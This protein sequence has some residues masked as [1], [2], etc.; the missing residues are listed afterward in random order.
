MKKILVIGAGIVGLSIAYYLNKH[1][2]EIKILDKNKAAQEASFAAAGMLAAQSEFEL[3]DDFMDQC[4]KSRD[5]YGDFCKD[6]EKESNIKTEFTNNGFINPAL[7][8]KQANLLKQKY[9][10]QNN[11]GFKIEL[12]DKKEVKK[13]EPNISDNITSA[14]HIKDDCQVNNRKLML[15]LKIANLRNNVKVIE[16]CEV[17]D[18]LISNNRI[19]GVNTKKGNFK[20]D[21]VVN[22]AGSWSSLIS[23]GVIPNFDVKPI[24]GQMLSLVSNKKL[25]T[26]TIFAIM[27]GKGCYIVPRKDNSIV[28]GST[29]EDIGF[30]KRITELGMNKILDNA[31]QIIPELKNLKI[32]E[33]WCAFR[34]Y[35][36]DQLPIIGKTNVENLI[37]A[38][39]HGRNGILLAPITAKAVTE[40]IVNDKVIP[41]IKD[42]G[43]ERFSKSNN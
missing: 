3:Y 39:A 35:A 29:I 42:L 7:N 17:E 4:I 12:L 6:I 40:L 16:N 36:N 11:K 14:L 9:E 43:V 15:A 24:L 13:L 21:I 26:K 30:E 27:Q 18:Y 1:N 41:E 22:A 28:L 31:V 23:Q 5:I 2:Y 20:A 8:E 34:P 38:T 32:K 10:W 33:K 19:N 25:L 37:L